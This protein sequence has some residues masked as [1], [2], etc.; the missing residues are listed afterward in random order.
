MQQMRMFCNVVM[1][2]GVARADALKQAA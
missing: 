2:D 1:S